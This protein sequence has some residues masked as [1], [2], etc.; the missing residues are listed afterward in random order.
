MT[1]VWPTSHVGMLHP[2]AAPGSRARAQGIQFLRMAEAAD[3]GL[4]YEQAKALFSD[5]DPATVE[6]RKSLY[7]EL[8][9]LYVPRY[10]GTLNL[11]RVGKQL[12]EL[13][14]TEPQE[15]IT[16]DLRKRVDSLICW[17][18]S[19]TQINRPQS[20]G[21]PSITD[22]D[23]AA[24]DIR[25]YA[26]FWQAMLELD[27]TISFDEFSRVLAHV[28]KA[29]DFEAAI[30]IIREARISGILPA[31]PEKSSNFGIYWRAHVGVA[32]S[33]LH[34]E[35]GRFTFAPERQRLVKSILQ[36]QMGCEGDDVTAAIRSTPWTDVE[37]YYAI[38][39]TECP[40]F[41]ASGEAS[42]ISFGGLPV[43][44]LRGYSLQEDKEGY[45]VDAGMELCALKITMPCFHT[46]EQRRLLRVDRKTGTPDGKVHIRLGMGRPIND[47]SQLLQLWGEQQ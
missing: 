46:S 36:F 7:E 29:A 45:F 38:A 23:R 22:A 47:P 37:S 33:L 5:V 26:A 6:T 39:G 44:M 21:S 11:T 32:D 43:V 17:A 1:F 3:K 20:L 15:V 2:L 31:A 8:G 14:G 35:N 18:M 12:L 4:S 27:N 16:E 34:F 28:Q 24:C 13:L 19:H 42:V 10:S 9:L 40:T 41:L 30:R 25:P